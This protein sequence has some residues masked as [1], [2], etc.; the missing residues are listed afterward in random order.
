MTPQMNALNESGYAGLSA[1]LRLEIIEALLNDV[2]SLP[3]TQA[4]IDEALAQVTALTKQRAEADKEEKKR[5]KDAEVLTQEKQSA[6]RQFIL[7]NQAELQQLENPAPSA[8]QAKLAKAQQ[9]LLAK[10]QKLE[11]A[12]QKTQKSTAAD[13][14]KFLKRDQQLLA[15]ARVFA[16]AVR[17]TPIGEDRMKR[18]YWWVD[19]AFSGIK[20]FRQT[21]TEEW[22]YFDSD[23]AIVS[24]LSQLNIKGVREC[25]L[26]KRLESFMD[27]TAPPVRIAQKEFIPSQR[28]VSRITEHD[29]LPDP[30]S[31]I[32]LMVSQAINDLLSEA[33]LKPDVIKDDLAGIEAYCCE[34]NTLPEIFR[35]LCQLESFT[36]PSK[37][38][39][40]WERSQSAWKVRADKLVALTNSN[41]N[42]TLPTHTVVA[43]AL[44]FQQALMNRL[45]D[46]ICE[47]CKSGEFTRTNQLLLCDSCDLGY[48]Q[49]CLRPP[50]SRVPSGDWYCPPCAAEKARQRTKQDANKIASDSSESENET[51]STSR[52]PRTIPI[53][54]SDSD[55]TQESEPEDEP[56]SDVEVEIDSHKGE[57]SMSSSGRPMRKCSVRALP[58]PKP[59]PPP[60]ASFPRRR[61]R[62]SAK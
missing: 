52:K 57:A 44:E 24:L 43:L 50:L 17:T 54:A 15:E 10:K 31:R 2:V 56:M 14:Q 30:V 59:R 53:Q 4:M 16:N 58:I 40:R 1:S 51:P 47:S 7:E 3:K 34:C 25:E 41:R 22:H 45:A 61:T 60:V 20:L 42:A 26:Q 32:K 39:K 28:K 21:R 11:D 37:V 13:A 36:D 62:S 48:H 18:R 49:M 23:G 19:T 27:T 35:I 55:N 33:T 5:K 8:D 9:A 29:A 6:L 38:S 12:V 46:S